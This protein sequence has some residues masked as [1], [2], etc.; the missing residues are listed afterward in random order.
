MSHRVKAR[1]LIFVDICV[2]LVSS[3]LGWLCR[4]QATLRLYTAC[5]CRAVTHDAG[6]LLLL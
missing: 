5:R 1:E 4:L 2:L 6:L 3:N